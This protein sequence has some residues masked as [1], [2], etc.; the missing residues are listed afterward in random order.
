MDDYLIAVLV[1]VDI[2]AAIMRAF[3]TIGIH[4]P[5]R[6]E[7]KCEKLFEAQRCDFYA[8]ADYREGSE[9]FKR[10]CLLL[11]RILADIRIAEEVWQIGA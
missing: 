5:G 8:P 10:T 1:L 2:L 9:L 3:S 6:S 4:P 7:D 11:D